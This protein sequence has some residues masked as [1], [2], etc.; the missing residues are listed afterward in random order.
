MSYKNAF[1]RCRFCH[2]E[3]CISCSTQLEKWEAEHKDKLPEPLFTAK[4]DDPEDMA[5]LK[6]CFSADALKETFVP[7]GGGIEEL[8]LKLATESLKQ[9][10]RVE[11]MTIT[12][13]IAEWPAKTLTP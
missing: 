5:A 13:D 10:L 3:G 12:P 8:N 9:G 2:G 11:A 7:M 4:L 6:R 1:S